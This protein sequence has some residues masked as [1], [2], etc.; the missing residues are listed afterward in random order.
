MRHTNTPTNRH[1]N[2]ENSN[3]NEKKIIQSF[4]MIQVDWRVY[5]LKNLIE[6]MTAIKFNSRRRTNRE[7]TKAYI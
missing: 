2:T 6:A 7:K 3:K 1:T 4:D 5:W